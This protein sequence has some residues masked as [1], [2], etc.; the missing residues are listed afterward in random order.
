M[1][2]DDFYFSHFRS[3]VVAREVLLVGLTIY[4]FTARD[5]RPGNNYF[6]WGF[7]SITVANTFPLLRTL[8]SNIPLQMHYTYII[9]VPF[10]ALGVVAIA[11]AMIVRYRDR[12][13]M[14]GI[15]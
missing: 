11:K 8:V 10:L 12:R 13:N 5:R 9:A 3:I 7:L 4:L 15:G 2:F 14:G 1:S 6:F